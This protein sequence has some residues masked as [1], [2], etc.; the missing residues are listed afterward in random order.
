MKY[1]NMFLFMLTK[2]IGSTFH[3]AYLMTVMLSSF[4]NPLFNLSDNPFR[5]TGS[6]GSVPEIIICDSFMIMSFR[7]SSFIHD[8]EEQKLY[9]KQ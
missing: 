2:I 4:F 7:D 5:S 9:A 8:K 3:Y 1:I 6:T